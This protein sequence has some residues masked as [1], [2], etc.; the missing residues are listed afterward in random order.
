MGGPSAQ[1]FQM[2]RLLRKLNDDV[3]GSIGREFNDEFV[4]LV[5]LVKRNDDATLR[6]LLS[7]VEGEVEL[8]FD[9][10]RLGPQL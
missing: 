9:S 1:V 2:E 6:A 4:R 5:S 8:R 7:S 10:P 3:S